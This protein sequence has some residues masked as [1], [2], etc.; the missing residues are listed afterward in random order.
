MAD[1]IEQLAIRIGDGTN[2]NQK[3]KVDT[4]GNLY[5]VVSNTAAVSGTVSIG[6]SL[7]SGSNLIGK[8]GIDQT[9]PGTTNGVQ[10]T[11]PGT[12]QGNPLYVSTVAA[13]GGP[14]TTV[15]NPLYE[16]LVAGS[17]IAG[18]FGIDQTTPGVTNGV[19]VNAAL[20]T[21]SNTIGNVGLV[22][23]T[24]IAGKFGIDQT[25][26]GVTNG[27]QVNASLPTG[28]NTIG[29]V[30]LVA[31]T[32]IIGKF[33]ID[34][35]TPGVTNGVQVN[36]ALPTGTNSLGTVGLNTGTNSIGTVGLNAGTNLVGKF[37]IDQTTPG[38]TNGVQVNAALPTGT[39][40]L[41]T[42]GLNTGTNSIGTV[43]LNAGTNLVGKFGIDQTT[44]GTTNAIQITGPGTSFANPLFV[45]TELG[46]G[47]TLRASG[48]LSSVSLATG[49][50]VTLAA[51]F[52]TAGKQGTLKHVDAAS[53]V[54]IKVEIQTVNNSSVATSVVTRF[55]SFY[56]LWTEWREYITGEL[57][58][59]T[60]ANGT[61]NGFAVKITNMDPGG[62]AADVFAN[63]VWTEA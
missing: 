36:A 31:G 52:V 58:A 59:Q 24:A 48:L 25:T 16:Q 3:A 34:Q 20:P 50:S 44:P 41:G 35:T 2:P 61:S 9:S 27:V 21:G 15:A 8:F 7:P 62:N 12:A 39:N 53:S 46:V 18:K 19:Q 14:G 22:A 54:A 43:G 55:N 13:S 4:S 26:P 51:P 5:V 28:T 42:V 47:V 63:V 30:G 17:A 40:S 60:A 38:V 32:A 45:S 11:G 56:Q 1:V 29:N 49:A 57:V 23:G 10:V 6:T 37:G 33:D